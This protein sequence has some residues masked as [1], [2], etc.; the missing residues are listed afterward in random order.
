MEKFD[1]PSLVNGKKKRTRHI[2]TK[3]NRQDAE[4]QRQATKTTTTA[5]IV[6]TCNVPE[7][8]KMQYQNQRG[9]RKIQ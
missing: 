3:K 8:S 5:S 6:V 2:A 4:R 7:I 1:L 9:T